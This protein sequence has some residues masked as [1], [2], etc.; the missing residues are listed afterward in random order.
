MLLDAD[1]AGQGAQSTTPSSAKEPLSHLDDRKEEVSVV[2]ETKV[3]FL[4]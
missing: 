2:L 3:D 1:P 4:T